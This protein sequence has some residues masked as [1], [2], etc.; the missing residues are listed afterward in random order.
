MAKQI[1]AVLGNPNKKDL[2]LQSKVNLDGKQV[3]LS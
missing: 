1:A 2:F 3:K